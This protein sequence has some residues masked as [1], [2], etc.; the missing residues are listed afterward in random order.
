MRGGR[1]T[2]VPVRASG[3]LVVSLACCLAPSSLVQANC[4]L[5]EPALLWSSPAQGAEDVPLDAD[6]LLVMEGASRQMEVRLGDQLLE[7]GEIP[8]VYDL[9]ALEPST[10]HVVTIR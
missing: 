7:A 8:G 3:L 2:S 6:L 4:A 1:A 5:P 10:E 9:G